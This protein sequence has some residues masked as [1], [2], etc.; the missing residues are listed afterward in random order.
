MSNL[1]GLEG[2]SCPPVAGRG[3]LVEGALDV[4]RAE[5][6]SGRWPV[7]ARIPPEPKLATMLGVSRNTAREAVRVLAHVGLLDV[8][9]GDGTYVRAMVDPADAARRM[10]RGSLRDHLEVRCVIEVEAAR[11]AAKRRTAADL[12]GLWAALEHRGTDIGDRGL[13]DFID[14]DVQFHLAVTAAAHNPS[15]TETY[16]Y[17]SRTIADHIQVALTDGALPDPGYDDHRAIVEA[18][19]DRDAEAAARA[20]RRVITIVLDAL[21][22]ARHP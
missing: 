5:L 20:A 21:D 13:T 12:E 19:A 17:F 14:R 6:A 11:F 2:L 7:G 16:R 4:L 9:Q 1:N 10:A 22:A 8:R 18:I 15:L 3:S